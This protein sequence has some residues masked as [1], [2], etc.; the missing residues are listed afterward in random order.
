M[1]AHVAAENR[2]LLALAPTP[3]ASRK[4][5]RA[6]GDLAIPEDFAHT[7]TLLVSEIVGNCVRHADMAPGERILFS[8]RVWTDHARIE[9]ADTGTGFDPEVRHRA[10][11]HGLRM[12]DKLAS[13]WGSERT[14]HGSRV[15][16]EVDRASGRFARN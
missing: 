7:V 11:G 15:W 10:E 4:A 6:L 8:A 3:D 2:T 12:L 16:F 5:R 14:D 1:A 13:R 9:V